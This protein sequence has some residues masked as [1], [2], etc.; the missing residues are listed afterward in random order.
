MKDGSELAGPV[1]KRPRLLA[2]G[3]FKVLGAPSG[4]AGLNAVQLNRGGP[5]SDSEA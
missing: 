5:V 4:P 3:L 1:G 2:E